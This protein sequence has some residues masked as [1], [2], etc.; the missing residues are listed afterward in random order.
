MIR[1]E[2]LTRIFPDGYP[3]IEFEHASVIE[4]SM[5]LA[6][7]P[8]LVNLSNTV[9]DGPAKIQRYDRFGAPTPEVPRS[10]VLSVT[11]GSSAEKGEWLLD[12]AV[13]GVVAAV[14]RGIRIDMS[15]VL[16]NVADFRSMRRSCPA[17][18]ASPPSCGCRSSHRPKG[19]TSP[20]TAFPGTAGR[21]IGRAH[22]TDRGKSATSRA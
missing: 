13:N 7:K 16:M 5:M 21:P 14:R 11:E 6:L 22:T 1:P 8:D 12:D 3:G 17:S 9:E 10:G 19:S 4:T 18:P 2:T 15:E 20:S